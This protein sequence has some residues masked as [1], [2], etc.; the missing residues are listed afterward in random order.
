MAYFKYVLPSTGLKILRNLS[1]RFTPPSELNDPFECLPDMGI[2]HNPV[3]QQEGVE[4]CQR[5]IK[6]GDWG[7]QVRWTPEVQ[8]RVETDARD[9]SDARK[10]RL[11]DD[12]RDAARGTKRI[13]CLSRVAPFTQK[14]IPMWAH[15]GRGDGADGEAHAGLAI[16]FDSAHKWMQH[17]PPSQHCDSVHYDWRRMGWCD[18]DVPD[19]YEFRKSKVWSPEREFRLV[20][21]QSS[22][23][24]CATV[25]DSLALIPGDLIRS[26]TLGLLATEETEDGVRCALNANSDLRRVAL[27]KVDYHTDKF[28][29]RRLRLAR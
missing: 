4:S 24:L 1:V 26:V 5:A 23:Y 3:F 20:R 10:R 6:A 2:L 7:P 16:E 18:N 15:Y 9:T 17:Q 13:F 11:S 21:V 28:A 12:F 19:G 22:P 8:T 27:W 29:F 14:S 25:V